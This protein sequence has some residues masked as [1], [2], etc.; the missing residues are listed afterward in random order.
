MSIENR[1]ANLKWCLENWREVVILA[2][3]FLCWEQDWYAPI[4]AGCVSFA[5]LLVWYWDPTFLTLFAFLGLCVSV[6]DYLGP[7]I[8]TKVFGADSWN[9]AKEK[10]FELVCEKLCSAFASLEASLK[11]LQAV[12]GTKP[13]AHFVA[14]LIALFSLAWVGNM[15]NNF[16]LAY[17]TSL[18]LAML[19]GLLDRQLLQKG[20][21]F[22]VLKL[23]DVYKS[24]AVPA[25]KVE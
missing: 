13:I 17:L 14:T 25:K 15:F 7:K 3:R 20:F 24:R 21:A 4:V 16:F 11:T 22:V 23:E 2:D 19:P 1:V 5:Y 6:A 18:L 12:R 8:I 9:G 10:H